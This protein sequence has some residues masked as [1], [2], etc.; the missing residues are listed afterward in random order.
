MLLAP[1]PKT[2]LNEYYTYLIY[3]RIAIINSMI[4]LY[5]MSQY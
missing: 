2:Y 5:S 3:Y 1:N 4:H